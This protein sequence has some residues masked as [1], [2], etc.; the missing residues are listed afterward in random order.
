MTAAHTGKLLPG[1]IDGSNKA[2]CQKCGKMH[3]IILGEVNGK[4][5]LMLCAVR[6]KKDLYLVGF[7]GCE[8]VE[9]R[10]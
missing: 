8:I 5:S 9:E 3:P 10:A 7:Q 4:P 1:I 2:K 6:C